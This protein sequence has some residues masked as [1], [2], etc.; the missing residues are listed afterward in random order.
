MP[1]GGCPVDDELSAFALGN[2]APDRVEQLAAHVA[3]C[4]ACH[5]RL[6]RF[7]QQSDEVIDGIRHSTR[8]GGLLAGGPPATAPGTAA[9]T[10]EGPGTR[11]GYY[12]LLELLGE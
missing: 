7:D 5:A 6:A 1:I 3:D 4:P 12:K 11:I 2:L 10:A 8:D 9:A